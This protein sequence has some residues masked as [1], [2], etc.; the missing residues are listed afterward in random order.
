VRFDYYSRSRQY[1]E[2]FA[3]AMIC[4]IA[5]PALSSRRDTH[6]ETLTRRIVGSDRLKRKSQSHPAR[7]KHCRTFEP[8]QS[9]DLYWM[10]EQERR[11]CFKHTVDGPLR[12]SDIDC[13]GESNGLLVKA[14]AKRDFCEILFSVRKQEHFTFSTRRPETSYRRSQSTLLGAS[15]TYCRCGY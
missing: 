3:G 9:P 7:R 12:V 6:C 2:E 10:K 11:E 14:N 5:I 15:D 4:R 8:A 13:F 1:S